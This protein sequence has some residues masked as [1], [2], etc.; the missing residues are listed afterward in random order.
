MACATMGK[1]L[2][3][4]RLSRLFDTSYLLTAERLVRSRA[5][6]GCEAGYQFLSDC[7]GFLVS[8]SSHIFY[9][10]LSRPSK[11]NF[12]NSW[13]GSGLEVEAVKTR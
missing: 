11:E 12:E 8:R 13:F 10:M 5:A 9:A 7:A 1:S 6:T 4:P 3:P 2:A